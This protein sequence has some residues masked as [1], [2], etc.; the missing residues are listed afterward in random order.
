MSATA[1]S[2]TA[3]PDALERFLD[4]ATVTLRRCPWLEE[5]L[6]IGSQ[7]AGAAALTRRSDIDL[8]LVFPRGAAA[9]LRTN[10]LLLRLRA[11]SLV[12]GVPLDLYAYSSLASL[13]RFRQ[14]EPLLVLLDRRNRIRDRLAHRTLVVKP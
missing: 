5:A 10:L 13:G 8:R 7:G 12:A 6:C 14:T 1:A 3:I 9:W 2:T 4:R 11:R